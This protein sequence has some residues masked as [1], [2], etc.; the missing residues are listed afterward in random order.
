MQRSSAIPNSKNGIEK[1]KLSAF[2]LFYP[3]QGGTAA[4]TPK[5]KYTHSANSVPGAKLRIESQQR[6]SVNKTAV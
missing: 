4:V 5:S 2:V 6:Q 3:P 1:Y